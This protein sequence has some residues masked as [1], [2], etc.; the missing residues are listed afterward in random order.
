[1][2]DGHYLVSPRPN[3]LLEWISKCA[4]SGDGVTVMTSNPQQQNVGYD[5]RY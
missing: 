2:K 4:T 3:F 1:M 5:T